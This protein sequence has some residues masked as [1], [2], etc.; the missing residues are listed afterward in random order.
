MARSAE[1]QSPKPSVLDNMTRTKAEVY[2]LKVGAR[3]RQYI[4]IYDD[5]HKSKCNYREGTVVGIWKYGFVV[6]LPT[7]KTFFRYNLLRRREPGE[8]VEILKA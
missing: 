8:R 5:N 4:T 6:Q 3:V 2:G 1:G 7:H